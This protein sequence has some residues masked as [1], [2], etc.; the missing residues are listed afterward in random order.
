MQT[1]SVAP[2]SKPSL[3]LMLLLLLALPIGI[4]A[5]A[6]GVQTKPLPSSAH[7]LLLAALI[8]VVLLAV[9]TTRRTIVL[10]H[11]LL[12]V[13]A[14]VYSRRLPV[15][16]FDLDAARIYVLSEHRD[17]RPWL[18][19]NGF[20]M[21][22]F[23]AGHFRDRDRSRVFCLVTADRVLDLPLVTGGRVLLSPDNPHALLEALRRAGSPHT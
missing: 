9:A 20:G 19:T 5:L 11:D 2:L 1:F 15:S 16:A 17:R 13:K 10:D 3:I 4:I 22:G 12:I 8:P 14:A 23:L 7:W 21:P 18:K 6:I